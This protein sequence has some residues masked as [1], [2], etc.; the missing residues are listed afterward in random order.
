MPVGGVNGQVRVPIE[1]SSRVAGSL[2]DA[3]S[4]GTSN[5][6][7]CIWNE[8]GARVGAVH[9][10]LCVVHDVHACCIL[11]PASCLSMLWCCCVSVVCIAHL[12]MCLE[13]GKCMSGMWSCPCD[14][15]LHGLGFCF[16][17]R[18]CLRGFTI[19][20]LVASVFLGLGL[21]SMR[22]GLRKQT[23]RHFPDICVRLNFFVSLCTQLSP[24]LLRTKKSWVRQQKRLLPDRCPPVYAIEAVYLYHSFRGI[25]IPSRQ[26]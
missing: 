8:V 3:G 11:H 21:C 25:I 19:S 7:R 12:C 6:D 23:D 14:H 5:E 10:T 13:S 22:S 18:H 9:L 15:F 20:G 4:Q 16:L 17:Q 2:L 26:R 1:E 24:A